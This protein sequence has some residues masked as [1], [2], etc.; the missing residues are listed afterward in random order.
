VQQ[1]GSGR[2]WTRCLREPRRR[3]RHARARHMSA[4]WC[5]AE[6]PAARTAGQ[7]PKGSDPRASPPCEREKHSRRTRAKRACACEA[8]AS[9]KNSASRWRFRPPRPTGLPP[10]GCPLFVEPLGRGFDLV[11]LRARCKGEGI[12][13]TQTAQGAARRKNRAICGHVQSTPC[14][15]RRCTASGRTTRSTHR[16]RNRLRRAARSTVRARATTTASSTAFRRR[17]RRV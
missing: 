6:Q 13:F 8:V 11:A 15:R 12:G 16:R 2:P 4:S 5:G 1:A 7:T 3:D 9:I 14:L 17:A 10:R